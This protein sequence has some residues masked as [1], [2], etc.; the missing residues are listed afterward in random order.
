MQEKYEAGSQYGGPTFYN[1]WGDLVVQKLTR[2]ERGFAR[3]PK[4]PEI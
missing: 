2:H 1:D 3:I 4:G